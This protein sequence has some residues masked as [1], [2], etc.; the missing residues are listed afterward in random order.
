MAPVPLAKQWLIAQH[1]GG[2]AALRALAILA[3]LVFA[4][5]LVLPVAHQAL[6]R[7]Q[8]CAEHGEW[9]DV[10]DAVPS[11]QTPMK[12]ARTHG[13]LPGAVEHEHSHCGACVGTHHQPVIAGIETSARLAPLGQARVERLS[14]GVFSLNGVGRYHVAPKQ[15][16]PSRA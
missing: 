10:H 7:H 6:V 11:V 1:E 4:G 5:Q 3:L 12:R 16:P 15:G 14:L 2:R 8:L 9:V 13:Y